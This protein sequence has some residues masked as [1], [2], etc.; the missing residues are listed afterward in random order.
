MNI[1]FTKL[2]SQPDLY[3]VVSH[4][5]KFTGGIHDVD[6][7]ALPVDKNIIFQLATWVAHEQNKPEK[8]QFTPEQTKAIARLT[9]WSEMEGG[10]ENTEENASVIKTYLEQQGSGF[11]I[12]EEVVDQIIEALRGQLTWKRVEVKPA[13]L[14]D[15]TLPLPLDASAS[16]MRHSTIPQLRDLSKRRG[17][18]KVRVG[19]FGSKF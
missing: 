8:V 18:G 13:P 12:T 9:Q 3:L 7:E 11:A 19:N 4:H 10:I 17:E 1:D 16:L 6:L 14:S 2:R 15:G 5:T